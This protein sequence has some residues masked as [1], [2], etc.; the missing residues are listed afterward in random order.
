MP[1]FIRRTLATAAALLCLLPG[2]SAQRLQCTVEV[3]YEAVAATHK[4][5][6]TEFE[7]D[8]R[9]YLNSSDWAT[10]APDQSIVCAINVFVNG[11]RGENEYTAQVFVGSQRPV[12]GSERNSAVLRVF[13]PAWEFSYLRSRPLARSTY[14]FEDLV[15]FLDFYAF[16]ILGYDYDTYGPGD[17]SPYF[18]KAADIA[19]LGRT[20]GRAGWEQKTGSFTRMQLIEEILNPRNTP[21]REAIFT[22]HYAGLDSL[23]IDPP[24]AFAN[25][26]A[27]LEVIGTAGRQ[28][29]AREA[30]VKSFFDAK[31][32]EI[33]EVFSAYPD[34]AVFSRLAAFDENHRTT[35]EEALRKPRPR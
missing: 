29:G 7:Q 35:Y 26:L 19:S 31:H 21:V 24:R 15:S 14:Q 20:S 34:P 33:A 8:L 32:L 16:L 6:L 4:D 25:M 9:N 18:R 11:V 27:A 2:A 13:D 3:N 30:F 5:K 10:E 17:G 12:F 23:A 22:Y 1:P 28:T